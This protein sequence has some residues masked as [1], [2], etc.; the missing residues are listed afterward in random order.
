M[1]CRGAEQEKK[2]PVMWPQAADIMG[3]SQSGIVG[4]AGLCFFLFLLSLF[5][6]LPSAGV[7]TLGPIKPP[8]RGATRQ[9]ITHCKRSAGGAEKKGWRMEEEEEEEGGGKK[10]TKGGE[11]E[12]NNSSGY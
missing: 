7:Q 6:S 5:R 12:R 4:Q 1:L 10:K 11:R 3:P 2:S 9:M 8:R